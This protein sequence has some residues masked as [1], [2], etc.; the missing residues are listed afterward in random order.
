MTVNCI[1]K[2]AFL[3]GI[4]Y[5][6]N[7]GVGDPKVDLDLRQQ[8]TSLFVVLCDLVTGQLQHTQV[9]G[10]RVSDTGADLWIICGRRLGR[11]RHF[12]RFWTKWITSVVVQGEHCLP[13]PV[14]APGQTID[15]ERL[16]GSKAIESRWL[17]SILTLNI[18]AGS[19]GRQGH[20]S[21]PLTTAF[22]RQASAS[23]L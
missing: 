5:V 2:L 3:A 13:P 18:C 6:T 10:H 17:N 11:G 20:P 14:S 7:W 12:Y 9:L 8:K 22:W 16:A 19:G 15:T 23:D 4:V 21:A 1:F